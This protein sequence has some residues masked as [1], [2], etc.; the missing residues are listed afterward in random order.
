MPKPRL[1]V[2]VPDPHP[3]FEQATEVEAIARELIEQAHPGLKSARIR[4]AFRNRQ[5]RKLIE[6]IDNY[7]VAAKVHLLTAQERYLSG[8]EWDFFMWV[9]RH[10]WNTQ[11]AHWRR[12]LVDHELCHLGV[13]ERTLMEVTVVGLHLSEIS[14]TREYECF[15]VPH[16]FEDFASVWRRNGMPADQRAAFEATR[17]L[18]LLEPLPGS[19]EFGWEQALPAPSVLP[20]DADDEIAD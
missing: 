20:A 10:I 16:D 12:Y 14:A 9:W 5:N 13:K 18:P 1:R 7:D 3:E 6:Q 8:S 4:F 19:E 17:S 2:V 11:S 15:T